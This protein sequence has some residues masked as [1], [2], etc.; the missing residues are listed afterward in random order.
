MRVPRGK[1][2]LLPVLPVL[3]QLRSRGTHSHKKG[4]QFCRKIRQVI[5][6]RYRMIYELLP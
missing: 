3:D 4:L 5:V 2:K 6:I 1:G